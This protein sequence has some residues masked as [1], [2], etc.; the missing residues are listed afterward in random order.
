M[1]TYQLK[2]TRARNN[3]DSIFKKTLKD[4]SIVHIVEISLGKKANGKRRR[5]QKTFKTLAVQS[6]LI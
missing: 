5:T 2:K 4:G 6:E 1:T 3:E